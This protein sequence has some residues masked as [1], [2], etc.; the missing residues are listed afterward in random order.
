MEVQSWLETLLEPSGLNRKLNLQALQLLE[1]NE[2][3]TAAQSCQTAKNGG[4]N[5]GK[6]IRTF[7]FICKKRLLL[8]M[9]VSPVTV[10]FFAQALLQAWKP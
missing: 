6:V 10:T 1:V 8:Q 7:I 4:G 2:E 3:R 9:E 5:L